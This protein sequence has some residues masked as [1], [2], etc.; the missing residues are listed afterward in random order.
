MVN[1]TRQFFKI[2]K[3]ALILDLTNVIRRTLSRKLFTKLNTTMKQEALVPNLQKK[4]MG[5]QI[6]SE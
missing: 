6:N 2:S 4:N 3:R 1:Y 5:Q